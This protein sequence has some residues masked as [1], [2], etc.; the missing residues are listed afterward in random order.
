M[1]RLAIYSNSSFEKTFPQGLLGL[2]KIKAFGFCLN[3]FSNSSLSKLNTGGCK[4]T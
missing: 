1:A 4:G 2:H 3:A